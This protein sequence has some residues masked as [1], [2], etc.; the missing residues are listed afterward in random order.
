MADKRKLQGKRVGY[1]EKSFGLSSHIGV[2]QESGTLV[3]CIIYHYL[4]CVLV[5]RSSRSTWPGLTSPFMYFCFTLLSAGEIDR[6]LKK[7]AEGV[8]QFEDVW[9][10]VRIRSSLLG[11]AFYDVEHRAQL[12]NV[13]LI[14]I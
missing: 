8:E 12:S 9:K 2:F 6:C 10:K 7:V 14:N 13:M 11:I 5:S 3:I 1:L 4:T